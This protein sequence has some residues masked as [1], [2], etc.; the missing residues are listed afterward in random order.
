[1]CNHVEYGARGPSRIVISTKE[2][3]SDGKRGLQTNSQQNSYRQAQQT[4][5]SSCL[6]LKSIFEILF[7]RDHKNVKV[8][9]LLHGDHWWLRT[10][11]W[12]LRKWKPN[13]TQVSESECD[14]WSLTKKFLVISFSLVSAAARLSWEL[15]TM[16]KR[17]FTLNDKDFAFEIALC[18]LLLCCGWL[19][20]IS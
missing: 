8:T 4:P 2:T 13:Y 6:Y 14:Q 20:W 12:F 11:N 7:Q 9:I 17:P 15:T 1:M 3:A 16:L 5:V 18:L 10:G 19:W